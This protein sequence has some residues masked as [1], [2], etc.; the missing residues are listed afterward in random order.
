MLINHL[1]TI[2]SRGIGNCIDS[3]DILSNFSKQKGNA[4][5]FLRLTMSAFYTNNLYKFVHFSLFQGA[6]I[7]QL[8]RDIGSEQFPPNEHYF[9][10]VNVSLIS[11]TCTSEIS[12]NSCVLEP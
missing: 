2:V 12:V 1:I 8:E 6:N 3:K 4:V 9:G 11:V 7:S 5:V 10:L